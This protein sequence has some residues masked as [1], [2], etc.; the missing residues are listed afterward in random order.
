MSLNEQEFATEK[1]LPININHH[2]DRLTRETTPHIRTNSLQHSIVRE[3][4]AQTGEESKEEESNLSSILDDLCAF[5][6]ENEE[7][8]HIYDQEC[9][10]LKFKKLQTSK[11]TAEYQRLTKELADTREKLI[12]MQKEEGWR[13][14][15]CS[16]P[17]RPTRRANSAQKTSQ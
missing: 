10:A 15:R 5:K 6:N 8:H 7:L 14:Q 3:S 16:Q 4:P 1:F 2:E 11:L 17:V 9:L 13:Y 12:S